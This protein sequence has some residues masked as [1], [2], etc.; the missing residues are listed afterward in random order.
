[1][2]VRALGVN[3]KALRATMIASATLMTAAAVAIAGVI[4]WI[5]LLIPHTARL[6]IG[7][8]F[9]QLLPLSLIL[10]RCVPCLARRYMGAHTR[11]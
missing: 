8:E 3:A 7:P 4:G 9:A 10:E 6:M 1:M 5:G 11:H 2:T